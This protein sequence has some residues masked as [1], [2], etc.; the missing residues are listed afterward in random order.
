[1]S[2]KDNTTILSCKGCAYEYRNPFNVC[3]FCTNF[4][5]WK[6]YKTKHASRHENHESI[7]SDFDFCAQPQ[8]KV[9]ISL[10]GCLPTYKSEYA[11][12]M[13]LHANKN[14]NLYPDTYVLIP[15]GIYMEIPSGYE[16]QVRPRSG[17]AA[18]H[19]VTVLNA[20]GT[21]DSDYRGE[22]KVLLINHGKNVFPIGK[23][24]R[25]AQLVIVKVEQVKLILVN[26]IEKLSDTTR[27]NGGFGSTGK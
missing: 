14:I 1:M 21:I 7:A 23:G 13:D 25:I 4:D 17:L 8:V 12:G 11:S 27:G 2:K 6:G 20:P 16:G 15:T 24:D 26:H 9:F 3:E 19:G 18:K 5:S 22:I 10:G